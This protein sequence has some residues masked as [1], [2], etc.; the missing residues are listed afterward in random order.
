MNR[1]RFTIPLIAI[2]WAG[3]AIVVWSQPAGNDGA[4]VD[5]AR[6][7]AL[8]ATVRR[9]PG[10]ARALHDYVEALGAAGRDAEI[11]ALLPRIDRGSAPV[12]ILARA[13]RAASNLKRFDLAVEYYHAALARAPARADLIAGLAYSLTDAGRPAEAVALLE[14]QRRLAWRQIPL[15]EAWSE[16]LRAQGDDAQGLLMQERI[17]TLDPNNR[18]AQRNRVF[19]LARLGAPHRALEIAAQSPGLLSGE[20]L[21]RLRS[22]R[23]AI[24]TRWGAAVDANA[25]DRFAGTD[26]A[27]ADNQALLDALRA[28]GKAGSAAERRLLFDRI[29]ALRNRVRMREAA[30]LYESLVS[31]GADVPPHAQ[32]AAADA[33]LYLEQPEKARDL[34]LQAL[35]KV[36]D[37]FAAQVNLFYAYADAGQYGEALAQI[38]RVVADTPQRIGAGGTATAADNPDYASAL[39][40]AGAARAHQDYLADAQQRLESFRALAPYNMEARE[41]LAGVYGAR[42]WLRAAEQEHQWILAAEPRQ[43]EA[44]IGYA[45]NLRDLQDWRAAEREALALEQQYPEDKHVQRIARRWR[46]HTRPEL[47]V[48]AGTGTSTGG[49]GPLGSRERALETWLYSAPIE[50][51]WRAFAHQYDASA[52]FPQGEAHRHRLGAGLEYRVRDLRLAGEISASRVGESEVGVTLTG[53]WHADDHWRLDAS[54][55][56]ESVDIPLQARLIGVTGESLRAGATYR[57]SESRSFGVAI[58]TIDFSDGNRRDIVTASAFQ[59]LTTGPVYKLDATAG[60]NTS[61]NSLDGASYFNPDSDLGLDATLIGEQRLW[62]RYDRDFVHRLHLGLGQYRQSGFGTGTTARLRYEHAWRLDERLDL[63]Y[64]AERSA[65][66]YDGARV[67]TS[68]Y[69]LSL[70][71]RF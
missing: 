57:V 70:A 65:H 69:N 45:D 6:L 8:E 16:A 41:K 62:R 7:R 12:D 34:Y 64:G 35:P 47:R 17:L 42:G 13:G 40:T 23:A 27:L 50:Y 9:D 51:D 38:D 26:S 52:R 21:L 68:H 39:A 29:E 22:D 15:L 61:A 24:A 36:E 33:Y 25:P 48:E 46:L 49:T 53:E 60:L 1:S 63:L 43:R 3:S 67:Y 2:L 14:G 30:E 66:P 37:S 59:R 28:D 19:T 56:S 31:D 4:G 5:S 10:N 55:Q 11:V 54:V 71:W 58:A 18:E 32:I 44:H 20:E